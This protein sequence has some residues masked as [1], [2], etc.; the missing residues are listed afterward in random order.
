MPTKQDGTDINSGVTTR[1]TF[2]GR[3]KT[4][5]NGSV[6]SAQGG[7]VGS[8]AIGRTSRQQTSNRNSG[9][10]N[11]LNDSELYRVNPETDTIRGQLDNNYANTDSALMKRYAAQG[12]QKS[13]ASG[14][15]N[16][17][18]AAQ[19]GMANVLDKAGEFA[20]V[21]SGYY[22]TRKTEN[23]RSGTVIETA[24]IQA[25]ASKYGADKSAK[26]QVA[27][28]NISAN[29]SRDVSAQN[30]AGALERVQLDVQNKT[31]LQVADAA[32]QERIATMDND[33]K[34]AY[35]S[36]QESGANFRASQEIMN[37]IYGDTATGIANIDQSSSAASQNSAA[38]RI[39]D[40][41]AIRLSAI[42]S[43]DSALGIGNG[44]TGQVGQSTGAA[45]QQVQG[46]EFQQLGRSYR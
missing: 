30:N 5:G 29:A 11:S 3:G 22:N 10:A 34:M 40:F 39:L 32:M 20:K 35:G 43:I 26:A 38:K 4:T 18:I 16:S 37:T 31:D 24:N 9:P 2:S 45:I 23:V 42:T 33:T 27:S 21:D 19:A 6:P 17:T 46:P 1:Q 13:V 25:D 14:L 7:N 36:L 12:R 28:A 41:Q 15:G 8:S 44:A